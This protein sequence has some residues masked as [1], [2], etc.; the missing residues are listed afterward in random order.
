M[1][2]HTVAANGSRLMTMTQNGYNR[3][4]VPLPGGAKDYPSIGADYIGPG[5][6]PYGWPAF[7]PDG[8]FFFSSSSDN[9]GDTPGQNSQLYAI[10]SGLPRPR[11]ERCA[12]LATTGYP[13]ACR[14]CFQPFRPMERTSP[15]V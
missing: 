14:Q 11:S 3:L 13:P 9:H 2:C 5:S 10:V 4:L 8:T 15:S 6:T 1:V 12:L 7:Y